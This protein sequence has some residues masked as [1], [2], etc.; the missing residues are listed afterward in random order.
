MKLEPGQQKGEPQFMAG[1]SDQQQPQTGATAV[2]DLIELYRLRRDAW[3]AQ[4]DELARLREEV[5]GSAE[6][7]AMEIVTAARRDVRKVITEA[8]RELLVL[9]A[10]VQAALGEAIPSTDPATLLDKAGITAH[11][12]AK[13]L[14]TGTSVNPFAPEAAVNEILSEAQAD[15]TDLAEDARALPLRPVPVRQVP[16]PAAAPPMDAISLP[17]TRVVTSPAA[18]PRIEIPDFSVT[19]PEP[20]RRDRP[21]LSESASK[22]LLTPP[23]PSDAVPVQMDRRFPALIALAVGIVATVAGITIWWLASGNS[24]SEAVSASATNGAT[25]APVAGEPSG[26]ASAA[27]RATSPANL[28][29]VAEA[30]RDVWIRTTIDGRADSGR[31]LAA[32][33]SVDISAERSVSLRVGDAGA[34]VVAVNN[35]EKRPLGRDGEV[36]TRQ[37]AVE[38]AAEPARAPAAQPAPAPAAPVPAAAAASAPAS[39]LPPVASAAPPASAT[40]GATPASVPSSAANLATASAPSPPAPAPA[41]TSPVPAASQTAAAP[42]QLAVPSGAVDQPSALAAPAPGPAAAPPP[43]SPSLVVVAVA[44]QW[45]DAYHRQDRA[46]MTALSTDNLL[47]TD[48]RG[49]D[50]RFPA[51]MPDVT[52]TL[53]RVSVQIAADTAVLTAVMMEQ[54]SSGTSPH[55]SPIS[56]VWVLGDGQWRVRQ[57]RFVSEARLNQVFK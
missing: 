51:G 20:E 3:I 6:R 28:S 31:T 49:A 34:L 18:E 13:N 39:E 17:P 32:G 43:T 11:P 46:T 29:V 50:E 4:A 57:A 37:F 56:Q 22:V 5:R 27:A 53:D 19:S 42:S 9:S 36:V 26:L 23:F 47:L 1:Q 38:G 48:E 24:S 8:R 12:E 16:A 44:R 14:L 15:I 25:P 21:G 54:S 41:P 7:E 35:E 45:L 30:V 40:R 55:V 33:E 10:Q 2:P 52:R